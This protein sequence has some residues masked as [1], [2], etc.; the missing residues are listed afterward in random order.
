VSQS[1]LLR[2]VN[3]DV[4]TLAE[5]MQALV[6]ARIRPYYLHHP[7]MAP[8]TGHFRVSVE[9]GQALYSALR[10]RVS[11]LALPHYVI[12][13]P[14]GVSKANAAPIRCGGNA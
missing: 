2:G 8:G 6:A 7:D 11:G 9:E 13:I 4:E 3:D 5:L 10:D 14:G 12:D 1:V